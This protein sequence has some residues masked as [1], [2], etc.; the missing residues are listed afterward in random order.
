[1]RETEGCWWEEVLPIQEQ[2]KRKEKEEQ[3]KKNKGY[4]FW[5]SKEWKLKQTITP[6]KLPI[7]KNN[8]IYL[9]TTEVETL[10]KVWFLLRER[11]IYGFDE[12]KGGL[13]VRGGAANSRTKKKERKRRT[14]DI[15]SGAVKKIREKNLGGAHVC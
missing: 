3:R 11:D 14:R 2:R 12:R 1:M 6:L 8:L 9:P 7:T 4:T 5:C 10:V 15:H 13:L